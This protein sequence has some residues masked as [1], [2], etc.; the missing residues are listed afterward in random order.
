[1]VVNKKGGEKMGT[2][3]R[4]NLNYD[5]WIDALNYDAKIGLYELADRLNGEGIQEVIRWIIEK[6]KTITPPCGSDNIL[7]EN[8]IWSAIE[9]LYSNKKMR[10]ICEEYIS[11]YKEPLKCTILSVYKNSELLNDN[12]EGTLV[13]DG[14]SIMKAMIY[15]GL[16]KIL[17]NDNVLTKLKLLKAKHVNRERLEEWLKAHGYCESGLPIK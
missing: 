12:L 3:R 14:K 1:M 13:G 2:K 9:Y 16:A 7:E 5:A 15:Y 8:I 6:Q 11:K 4:N 10:E 17:I